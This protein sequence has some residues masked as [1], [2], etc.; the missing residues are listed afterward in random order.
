M[1]FSGLVTLLNLV[2]CLVV[3]ARLLRSGMGSDRG[4]ERALA[5]YFLAS[6]FFAT[7]CQ[8]VSYGA[9]VDPRLVLPGN[10]SRWILGFGI[11]G[12][13]I[14]GSAVA[15]FTWLSFHR[16]DATA[17]RAAIAISFVAIGGFVFE[18]LHEG[19]AI[20]LSPG[21]GH[22]VA[23]LGRTAPV[24]W[25]AVESIRY[26]LRLR[27]RLRIGLADPVVVNRFF[28]WA[29]WSFATLANL[30]ADPVARLIYRTWAGTGPEVVMAVIEPV[31]IGTMT[32]T[33]VLG[34]VSAVTLVLTFFPTVAYRNWIAR[35]A[36]AAAH[37]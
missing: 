25:V 1:A 23:W 20:V 32:V 24:A 10:A 37:A 4:P 14:G 6:A 35:R 15:V 12:M 21:P 34:V 27:R 11:L 2:L 36:G 13:A 9:I 5:V 7:V 22:W 8:A 26:W 29:V 31:V 17:R 28:L 16:D 3:G 33:M 19:F 30:T 18:A